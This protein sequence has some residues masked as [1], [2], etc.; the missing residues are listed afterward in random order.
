[1]SEVTHLIRT[2]REEEIISIVYGGRGAKI[3]LE[4]TTENNNNIISYL[5]QVLGAKWFKC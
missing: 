5:V 3:F 2:Q 4:T 1:M